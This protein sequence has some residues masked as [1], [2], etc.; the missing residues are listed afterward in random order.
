MKRLFNAS[1]CLKKKNLLLFNHHHTRVSCVLPSHRHHFSFS[2]HFFL[3]D[4]HSPCCAVWPAGLPRQ[5]LDDDAERFR[6]G[7]NRQAPAL[8]GHE[9][10]RGVNGE[11]KTDSPSL[12]LYYGHLFNFYVFIFIWKGNGWLEPFITA[13]GCLVNERVVRWNIRCFGF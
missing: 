12:L 4:A 8:S 9:V 2:C 10:V 3:T 6:A 13:W 11:L 7:C 1:W 5:V